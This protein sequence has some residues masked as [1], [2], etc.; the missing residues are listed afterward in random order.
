MTNKTGIIKLESMT[1]VSTVI[2]WAT[3]AVKDYITNLFPKN[4]FNQIK[5]AT[6]LKSVTGRFD[7]SQKSNIGLAVKKNPALSLLVNYEPQDFRFDGFV[8]SPLVMSTESGTY[9]GERRTTFSVMSDLDTFELMFSDK[10]INLSFTAGIRVGTRLEAWNTAEYLMT[11]ILINKKCFLHD[12][13]ILVPIPKHIVTLI[14]QSKGLL[15]ASEKEKM[16][17]MV[18]YADYPIK[19][20]VYGGTNEKVYAFEIN[21]NGLLSI[22][23]APTI[24]VG[25]VKRAEMNSMIQFNI[26]MSFNYPAAFMLKHSIE[27]GSDPEP[28]PKDNNAIYMMVESSYSVPREII[29]NKKQIVYV[30]FICEF[31]RPFED[32]NFESII[33]PDILP[34]IA[35]YDKLNIPREAYLDIYLFF[36]DFIL[37]RAE[38]IIDWPT[39]H[40]L[41]ENPIVNKNYNLGL[42]LDM[43]YV[44]QYKRSLIQPDDNIT[45]N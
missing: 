36:D 24:E 21:T 17:C 43:A 35:Y 27:G 3:T 7:S 11:K 13:K 28:A 9:T 14:L 26:S 6:N 16:D 39:Y 18:R 37:T 44:E 1:N 2:G 23:S 38:Y 31:N 12:I 29:D 15:K 42:Y 40:L 10:R 30:P 8:P 25:Q 34:L 45:N 5:L 19:H 33:P 32:L 4:Y 22:E 20:I 41:L